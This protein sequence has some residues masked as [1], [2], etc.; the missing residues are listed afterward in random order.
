LKLKP[1]NRKFSSYNPNFCENIQKVSK[2]ISFVRLKNQEPW[3]KPA[4]TVR[5]GP[6]GM[7]WKIFFEI[8][9]QARLNELLSGWPRGIKPSGWIKDKT[10]SNKNAR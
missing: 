8:S 10:H 3:G 6:R 7:N 1:E 9:K 5:A 4:R 2:I